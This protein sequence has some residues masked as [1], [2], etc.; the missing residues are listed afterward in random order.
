VKQVIWAKL[1]HAQGDA[2]QHRCFHLGNQCKECN[3]K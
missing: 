3:E 2:R 1:T